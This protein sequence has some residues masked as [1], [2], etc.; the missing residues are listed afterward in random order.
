[1]QRFRNISLSGKVTSIIMATSSVAI[2]LACVAVGAYDMLDARRSMGAHASLLAEIIGGNSAAALTF[3]D[4]KAAEDV[5]LALR[6]EPHVISACVFDAR[7]RPFAFYTRQASTFAPCPD[8]LP[9]D[10]T[11][12]IRDRMLQFRSITLAA[13]KLGTVYIEFDV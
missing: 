2:L 12:F 10:G 3:N 11:Y 5:L 1:M 6:A 9:A 4:P 8:K 7:Q 13:D